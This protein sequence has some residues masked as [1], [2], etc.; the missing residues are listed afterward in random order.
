MFGATLR[1]RETEI[2]SGNLRVHIY[3]KRTDFAYNG[4]EHRLRI[5]VPE[6][7]HRVRVET[8]D[9]QGQTAVEGRWSRADPGPSRPTPAPLTAP[10]LTPAADRDVRRIGGE[11]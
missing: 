8:Y 1:N 6:R 11:E 5:R 9:A 10:L 4:L 3:T 2:I 7:R